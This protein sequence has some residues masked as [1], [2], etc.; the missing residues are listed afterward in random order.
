MRSWSCSEVRAR[1]LTRRILA[2][3]RGARNLGAAA[4]IAELDARHFTFGAGVARRARAH[5]QSG[6]GLL[7]S[8]SVPL[9]RYRRTNRRS[10]LTAHS[11]RAR[12]Y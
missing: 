8:E 3:P 1:S 2:L 4:Q 6:D 11:A 7:L 5:E 10:Y 9:S 12:P